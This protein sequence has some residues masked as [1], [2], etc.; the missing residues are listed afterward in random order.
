MLENEFKLF[1]KFLS[2]VALTD[3]ELE[4]MGEEF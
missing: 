2:G 4:R 1:K 3:E